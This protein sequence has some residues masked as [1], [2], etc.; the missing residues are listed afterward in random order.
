MHELQ[1]GL[2]QGDAEFLVRLP[3]GTGT[4]GLVLHL[5]RRQMPGVG[6]EGD[7]GAALAEEEMA[8][9]FEY[10]MGAEGGQA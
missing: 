4:H 10:E 1:I 2:A 9:A 7:A 8:V 6:R 3:Y 5:T